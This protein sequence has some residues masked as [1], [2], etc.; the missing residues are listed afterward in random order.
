[1]NRNSTRHSSV[2][3]SLKTLF[4]FFLRLAIRTVKQINLNLTTP[5]SL[6]FDRG[7]LDTP[8][9]AADLWI[10]AFPSDVG[11]CQWSELIVP[12]E[13]LVTKIALPGLILVTMQRK[14]VNQAEIKKLSHLT[15]FVRVSLL[16]SKRSKPPRRTG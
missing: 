2:S 8:V 13:H 6:Y 9:S 7:M 10:Y 11:I 16:Q 1:M 4:F 3:S 14:V 12:V 15:P 5:S